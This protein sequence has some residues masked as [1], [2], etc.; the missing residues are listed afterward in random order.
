MMIKL[1]IDDEKEVNSEIE[2][3]DIHN[4]PELILNLKSNQRPVI[5]WFE[6]S[7]SE[8]E[9]EYF[10]PD[11]FEV[12]EDPIIYEVIGE[13]SIYGYKDYWGEYD[14][15]Y[16]FKIIEWSCKIDEEESSL[17]GK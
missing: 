17:I 8:I 5:D 11:K 2:F 12:C 13:F 10:L 6:E 4:K 7:I 16:E 3:L 1:W 14:E 9:T 15:E